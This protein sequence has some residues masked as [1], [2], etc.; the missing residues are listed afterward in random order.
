ME[1]H[2]LEPLTAAE[3]S[4][5]SAAARKHAAHLSLTVR[6][7]T[8]SLAE[9]AKQEQLAWSSGVGPRP[10]RRA[11]CVLTQPLSAD[12][13]EALVELSSAGDSIFGWLVLDGASLD[14]QPMAT[15]DDCLLAERVVRAD[16]GVLEALLKRGIDPAT[17]FLDPWAVVRVAG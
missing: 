12:V 6:F 8:I 17:L 10:R 4:R 14:G 3:V 9:P 13:I 16:A 11:L 7:N 5:A 15:P 1:P 2:P